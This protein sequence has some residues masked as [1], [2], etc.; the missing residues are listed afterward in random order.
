MIKKHKFAASGDMIKVSFSMMQFAD[1]LHGP[2][3]LA[4]RQ[5]F[6]EDNWAERAAKQ[7]SSASQHCFLCP[8]DVNL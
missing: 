1:Q 8:F 7:S 5:R 3:K 2:G 4:I 6:K